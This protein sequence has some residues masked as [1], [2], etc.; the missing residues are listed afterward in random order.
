MTYRLIWF[1]HPIISVSVDH[2]IICNLLVDMLYIG[3]YIRLALT[4]Y[5]CYFV[6]DYSLCY[7]I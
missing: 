6:L 7:V 2:V 3:Y 4:P 1:A 5:D